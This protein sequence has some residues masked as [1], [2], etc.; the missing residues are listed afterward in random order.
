[1]L[2]NVQEAKFRATLV[3]ISLVVLSPADQKYL[4]FD[5][6][7][8]HIVAHELCHGLGP[9]QI[10]VDGRDTNPRMELKDQYSAWEEAKA[11][12]TGLFALQYLMTQADK[13]KLTMPLPH[14]PEAERKLYTTYLA[15]S[16]RTMRFGLQDAHARG[17]AMQ[18]NFFLMKGAYLPNADGTFSL[19][20][21]KMKDA[22]VELDKGLLTAEAKGDYNFAKTW[23]AMNGDDAAL[24]S[25]FWIL[26]HNGG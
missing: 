21:A 20:L 18:F 12:V 3:P 4:S 13:G 16:F 7:F 15:S 6:F 1:M 19:D 24:F 11:D 22:V 2:K 5:L 26:L 10:K 8:T 25:Q 17:Q 9:H 23:M 14:G